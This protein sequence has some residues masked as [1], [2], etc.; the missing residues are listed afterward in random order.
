METTAAVALE[1]PSCPPMGNGTLS[2]IADDFEATKELGTVK[3]PLEYVS[4]YVTGG[5]DHPGVIVETPG[6][7]NVAPPPISY[8]PHLPKELS[9]DGRLSRMQVERIIYAGQAHEQ[10][11]A[12]GRGPG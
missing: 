2:P 10:R 6:L 7:S 12:N 5:A 4:R 3:Q 9:V 1:V 8:R 11:L